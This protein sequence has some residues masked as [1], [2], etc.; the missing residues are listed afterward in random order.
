MNPRRTSLLAIAFA[1]LAAPFASLASTWPTQTVRFIVPFPP[2]GSADAL[3]R[4]LAQRLQ[5]EW[6]QT[7][8]VDNRPGGGTIIGADAVAKSNDAHTIGLVIPAFAVNPSI[9]AQMPYDT[10]RDLAGVTLIS[11]LPVALF[12]STQLP[13]NNV[14]E[15][16]AYA[17][18]HPRSLSYGSVGAG[19]T[20]HLAGQMMNQ[21]AGIDMVHVPYKGSAPAQIDLVA[22][23]LGVLFDSF[24]SA[25]PM[26]Q[27]GRIKLVG[28]GT[29]ERL[30][31]FPNVAPIGDTV[32][33][34][35]VE[36]YFGVI[37]P[38]ST[39][40]PVLNQI[41]Q[42]IKQ[43]IADPQIATWMSSQALTPIGS[44]PKE[45]DAFLAADM[46][47]WAAVVKTLGGKLD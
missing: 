7:V 30:P 32:K 14:P 17:K 19:S 3:S 21:L 43:A 18:A 8:V 6:K 2:G 46:K 26:L 47:K 13:V 38:R 22:G 25:L 34:F 40:A 9:N 27:A 36:S 4:M 10:V 16:I 35:V 12:A 44:T 42:S 31:G 20:S 39:P 5:A 41:Q 24:V 11:T 33:G 15:L 1:M 37:A 28:A 23:R 29:S 45:F